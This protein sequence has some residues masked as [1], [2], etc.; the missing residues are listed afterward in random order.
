[1]PRATTSGSSP[2]E[3]SRSHAPRRYVGRFAPSP[4]GP[5]HFGSLVAAVA[6][7]LDARAH[8]GDWLV[9][10]ED[11]DHGRTIAGA[12]QAILEALAAHGMHWDERPIHQSRRERHYAAAF[13]RLESAGRIFACACSRSEIADTG[14]PGADGA[15]IYP[16]TCRTALPAGRPARAWRVRVDDDVI[17][18]SD[19]LAGRIAQELSRDVGDFILKRADGSWAYQLA[20]VVDDALQGV[21]DVVRGADLLLSTPR[22][23]YLQRCLAYPQVRYLHVP[24]VTDAQGDK[25][26]KQTGATALDLKEPVPALASAALHLGL[27]EIKT[28]TVDAFWKQAL[29]RWHER[30]VVPAPEAA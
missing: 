11:L 23:I 21:T 30:H 24:L 25:L 19:R 18:F 20:V 9:R 27:G 12:T 15:P 1:M 4:T 13:D 22:Q 10:I 26:S 5:L 8:A 28:A 7:Y 16:G 3:I 14:R 2:L 17:A 6:S 29:V